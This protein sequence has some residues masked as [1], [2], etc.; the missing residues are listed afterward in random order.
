M[1]GSWV[2]RMGRGGGTL[3]CVLVKGAE[4]PGLLLSCHSTLLVLLFASSGLVYLLYLGL[5]E[6]WSVLELVFFLQTLV[7]IVGSNM[8]I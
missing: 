1:E 2:V 8:K 5:G 6:I 4:G 3:R 7:V